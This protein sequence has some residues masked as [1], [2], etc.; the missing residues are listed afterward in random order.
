[1]AATATA[2][3]PSATAH[4]SVVDDRVECAI[5]G[6]RSHSLLDHVVEVHGISVAEYVA[7]H[8]GSPTVSHKA[9]EWVKN[10]RKGVRRSA[11]STVVNLTVDVMGWTVPVNH[12]SDPADCLSAPEGYA[13]PTK[14]KAKAAMDDVLGCLA[15]GDTVFFWGPPGTGKDSVM[16]HYSE[17]TQTPAR[18]FSFNPK[19]NINDWFYSLQMTREGSVWVPGDLFLL[20]TQG[21]EGAE[22]ERIPALIVFSD[23]DRA[24]PEQLESFRN[25]IDT[26]A[27]SVMPPTGGRAV[28]VLPGTQFAFT[29]NSCG[30][31]GSNGNSSSNNMDD[32][33]LDR[34]GEFVLAHYMDWS[35]EADILRAKFPALAEKAPN[36]FVELGSAVA[37]LRKAMDGSHDTYELEARLTHRG[38]CTICKRADRLVRHGKV[39]ADKALKS[40]FRAWLNSMDEDN[41]LIA[42]R[43]I[44]A[45]VSGGAFAD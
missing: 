23:I 39:T 31:G 44:D 27:N 30:T 43:L 28:P 5:C 9:I 37:N 2:T 38:L 24:T 41:Q 7:A 29:A 25:I 1:M 36:L 18:V 10:K 42:K 40:G 8:P 17:V 13:L 3:N 33:M 34:M 11:A 22:G 14:G 26:T 4:L 45:V 20:L 15:E 6:H 19:K 12:R 35:D 21:A 16:Y 32:S